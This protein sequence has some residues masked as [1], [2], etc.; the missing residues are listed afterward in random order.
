MY[1]I[2]TIF[3][4]RITYCTLYDIRNVCPVNLNVIVVR[5]TNVY[6]IYSKP[7]QSTICFCLYYK[8]IKV[9]FRVTLK[10]TKVPHT[11]I[12]VTLE[13]SMLKV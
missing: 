13:N 10:T 11:G 12:E 6:S 8:P 4:V 2:H 1:N 9:K 3:K 7:L 5:C